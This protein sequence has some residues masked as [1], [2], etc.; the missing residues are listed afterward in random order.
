LSNIRREVGRNPHQSATPVLD[1]LV[2]DCSR[3]LLINQQVLPRQSPLSSGTNSRW[4]WKSPRALA[5]N[6]APR[7][8][9]RQESVVGRGDVVL[10]PNTW[11]SIELQATS[12]VPEWGGQAVRMAQE[13]EAMIDA[14]GQRRWVLKRQ[15]EL[16]L[17]R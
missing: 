1:P 8:W 13:E 10:R 4:R 9:D 14:V 6:G 16:H 7:G 3:R 15:A 11:F 12:P 2:C 17:V 5:P